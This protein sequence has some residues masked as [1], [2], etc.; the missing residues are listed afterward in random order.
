VHLLCG[1]RARLP[2]ECDLE[3]GDVPE[4]WRGAIAENAAFFVKRR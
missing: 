2:R 1:V 4:Q 3:D